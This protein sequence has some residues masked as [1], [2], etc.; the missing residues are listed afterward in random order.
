MPLI[1]AHNISRLLVSDNSMLNLSSFYLTTDENGNWYENVLWSKAVSLEFSVRKN[2]IHLFTSTCWT[3][4]R[5]NSGREHRDVCVCVWGGNDLKQWQQRCVWHITFQV[6]LHSCQPIKWR[7]PQKFIVVVT[8]WKT[9]VFAIENFLFSTVL[10][11]YQPVFWENFY[12]SKWII[13]FGALLKKLK[14]N[15]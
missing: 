1:L 6:A 14:E 5:A 2:C 7:M 3:I 13:T 4:W 10:L 12:R 15:C 8:I 11:C 9:S